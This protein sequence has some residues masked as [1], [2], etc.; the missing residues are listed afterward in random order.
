MK[1]HIA[2]LH[3]EV[4]KETN[5][6]DEFLARLS[7]LNGSGPRS[8]SS[9]TVARLFGSV[10]FNGNIINLAGDEDF[11][12]RISSL[13]MHCNAVVGDGINAP[14]LSELETFKRKW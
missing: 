12:S 11:M 1:L 6:L 3:V 7:T 9:T 5:K 4:L 8:V 2:I 10:P 14:S 13:L